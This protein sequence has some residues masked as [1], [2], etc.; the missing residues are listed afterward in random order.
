[1][2][3]RPRGADIEQLDEVSASPDQEQDEAPQ[4][5]G[6]LDLLE[7]PAPAAP[8]ASVQL[9]S[10]ATQGSQRT[11]RALLSDVLRHVDP[12]ASYKFIPISS[13]TVHRSELRIQWTASGGGAPP[14]GG[15]GRGRARG[16][17]APAVNIT[18]KAI[19]VFD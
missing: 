13:G 5:E 15:G 16:R 10:I 6:L 4:D 18:S 3:G 9:R 17:A 19:Q 1:V 11:P 8:D 12:G 2:G 7:E 14:R